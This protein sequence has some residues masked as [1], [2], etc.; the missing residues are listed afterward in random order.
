MK[1]IT[2]DPSN[3]KTWGEYY[4]DLLRIICDDIDSFF[5][6]IV[7]CPLP[8]TLKPEIET[9]RKKNHGW[10]IR[11]YRDIIDGLYQLSHPKNTVLVPFG[12]SSLPPRNPYVAFARKDSP[13]W[14]K[15][16]NQL[17]HSYYDSMEHATLENVVDALTGLLVLNCLHKCSQEYLI[18]R[19]S[20]ENS[21]LDIEI[22]S[23]EPEGL[24]KEMEKSKVG[25][26]KSSRL[27]V[28]IETPLFVY[29]LP[30]DETT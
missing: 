12:W 19:K 21:I 13:N 11:G 14:W 27:T 15:A 29:L 3:L 10:N 30:V 6:K 9:A 22:D 8:Q 20:L 1:Y 7:D 4:A 5:Q 23:L 24:L 2:F 26:P 28:W 18:R 16:Y 25:V 17:K